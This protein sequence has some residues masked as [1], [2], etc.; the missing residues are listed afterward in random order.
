MPQGHYDQGDTTDI[1]TRL[2]DDHNVWKSYPAREEGGRKLQ[3]V[4][5]PPKTGYLYRDLL[6]FIFRLKGRL[7]HVTVVGFDS[8]WEGIYGIWKKPVG[9][10]YFPPLDPPN[11]PLTFKVY[12]ALV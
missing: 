4:I 10:A 1:F 11:L 5:P 8:S 9:D 3:S 12:Q 6:L 2:A 7:K